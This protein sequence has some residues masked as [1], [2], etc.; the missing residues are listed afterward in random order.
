[1]KIQHLIPILFLAAFCTVSAQT[2]TPTTPALLA[3]N[4]AD[5]IAMKLANENLIELYEAELTN[6]TDILRTNFAPIHAHQAEMSLACGATMTNILKDIVKIAPEYPQLSEIGSV[7]IRLLGNTNAPT[8][9]LP[10]RK[11]V[12]FVQPAP[13]T[14]TPDYTKPLLYPNL[15]RPQLPMEVD[16]NGMNLFITLEDAESSIFVPG[17][18]QNILRV[19]G[20]SKFHLS[21]NV[22]VSK[23]ND[24]LK[25]RINS[26]VE[27][28]VTFLKAYLRN[29]LGENPEQEKRELLA[30]AMTNILSKLKEIGSQ[31]PLLSNLNSATIDNKGTNYAYQH[32]RYWVNTSAPSEANNSTNQQAAFY[33]RPIVEMGGMGLDVYLL[34][35]D[36][37]FGFD[38]NGYPLLVENGQ[39]KVV[40]GY[41]FSFNRR[42]EN[43]NTPDGQVRA[44]TRRAVDK[45]IEDQ[46]QQLRKKL[47]N[48]IS[49]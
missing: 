41:R 12:H 33:E 42:D 47:V 4:Q 6:I 38:P 30:L 49:F 11:G 8:Y 39:P 29:M 23:P 37:P 35:R 17:P 43:Y 20:R 24:D 21:C 28:N 27:T 13:R 18:S 7:S 44:A 46:E 9:Q 32:L 15:E 16:S 25:N 2:N 5:I 31:Y 22:T 36:E 45:I 1:M 19:N 3:S 48:I 10:Y 14:N 34:N 26:I 40:L